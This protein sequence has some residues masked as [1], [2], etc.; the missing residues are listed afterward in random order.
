[1][2]AFSFSLVPTCLAE[3]SVLCGMDGVGVG[4]L[5]LVPILQEKFPGLDRL[6]AVGLSPVA[7]IAQRWLAS[8]PSVFTVL[9]TE[10]AASCQTL[11]LHLSSL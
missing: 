7:L 6:S 10:G 11:F 1:M 9:I 5:A 2:E 8:V 3:T 4:I